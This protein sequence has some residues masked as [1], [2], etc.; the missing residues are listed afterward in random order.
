M[1][2]FQENA[3]VKSVKDSESVATHKYV[4]KFTLVHVSVWMDFALVTLTNT[5]QTYNRT[6]DRLHMLC[7]GGVYTTPFHQIH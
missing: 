3:C 1:E 4:T 2:H 7:W 5:N 6:H